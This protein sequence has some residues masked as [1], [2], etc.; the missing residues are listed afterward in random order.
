MDTWKF[1]EQIKTSTDIEFYVWQLREKL[2]TLDRQCRKFVQQENKRQQ[3]AFEA[4][5]QHHMDAGSEA[6]KQQVARAY[7][8]TQTSSIRAMRNFPH[9]NP[10]LD[11][12]CKKFAS[13]AQKGGWNADIFDESKFQQLDLSFKDRDF[14]QPYKQKMQPFFDMNL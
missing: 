3:R 2:S 1:P 9:T 8:R 6:Q 4:E 13:P 12:I 14:S 7:A 5:L 11:S 10:S